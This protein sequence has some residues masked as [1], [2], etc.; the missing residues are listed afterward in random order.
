[1][2]AAGYVH[3]DIKI[4]NVLVGSDGNYKLC[5]FG[6]CTNLIVDFSAMPASDYN[7][8]TDEIEK[9]TTPMYRSPEMGDP[10]RKYEVGF[11]A[12][13]WMLGCVLYT[14]CYFVHP[15]L[16]ATKIGISRAVYRIPE[17]SKHSDKINDL[18]RHLLTPNPSFRP[19][20]E[21]VLDILSEWKS[22]KRIP[23]N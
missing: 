10:C 21:S 13:V 15:F 19:S 12:D 5:D 9:N 3:R 18:I 1:V 11:K 4:E 16:E 8:F 22:I 14:L 23:L 7:D 17:E 2:H 6:S 20:V